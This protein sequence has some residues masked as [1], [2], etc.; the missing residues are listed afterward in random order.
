MAL[1]GC[2]NS[3]TPAPVSP[4]LPAPPPPPP[5]VACASYRNDASV[6]VTVMAAPTTAAPNCVYDTSFVDHDAPLRESITLAALDSGGV[7]VFNGSLVVG[8]G[9]AT[10]AD[11]PATAVVL[12]IEAGVTIAF[13][14][15]DGRVIINRGAQIMAVGTAAD[16]I[17]FTSLADVVALASADPADDLA[18]DAVNQWG[19]SPSMV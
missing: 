12:T 11:V 14:N 10:L 3:N 8:E 2:G 9:S 13:A 19:A 7:H 1:A 4:P 18:A 15:A 16:P 17:T 5:A 6:S